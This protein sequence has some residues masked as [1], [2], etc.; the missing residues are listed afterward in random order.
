MK[1]RRRV[2]IV[3]KSIPSYRV[4]FFSALRRELDVREIDLILVGGDP[5][6]D[7]RFK[8]DTGKVEGALFRPNRRYRV[9]KREFVWQPVLDLTK[10]VDLV[11]VEQASKLLVNYFLLA[12]QLLP[13]TPSVAMWGHGVNLQTQT[14]NRLGEYVKKLVSRRSRW[15]FA[16]TEGTRQI[17]INKGI[18]AS[19]ITVVQNSIDAEALRQSILE[20]PAD[21]EAQMRT[22]WRCATGKTA[23]FVGGLYAEKRLDFLIQACATVATE[24]PQFRLVIAGDGPDRTHVEG[25]VKDLDFVTYIGRVDGSDRVSLLRIADCIVMPGLVGLAIIDSFVAEAPLITTNLKSHS[26]EIEYL[27]DGINGICVRDSDDPDAFA[28]AVKNVISSGEL[29]A[30]LRIGCRLSAD[31]YSLNA[32]VTRFADGIELALVTLSAD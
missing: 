8:A 21:I 29:M 9:G 14:A 25:L 26:P 18:P 28:K 3:Q 10:S 15:W 32:M 24:I 2:L 27:E 30:R 5:V 20:L 13:R 16:Y 31:K 1:G 12:R 19:R 7:D 4:A 11:I 6:G 23:V 22:L 17:M